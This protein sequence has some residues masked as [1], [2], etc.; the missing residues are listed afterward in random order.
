MEFAPTAATA[1]RSGGSRGAGGEG[2]H[3]P[4]AHRPVS[5]PILKVDIKFKISQLSLFEK[6]CKIIMP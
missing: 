3:P 6:K 4:L 1:T 5:W 2:T